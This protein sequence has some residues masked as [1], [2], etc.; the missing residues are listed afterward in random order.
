MTYKKFSANYTQRQNKLRIY[1]LNH[2]FKIQLHALNDTA[3]A[4]Q[5]RLLVNEAVDDSTILI[6][7]NIKKGINVSDSNWVLIYNVFRGDTNDIG[8]SKDKIYVL[9][10]NL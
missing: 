7:Q 10:Y 1:H 9:L 2:F 8:A 6:F 5:F 3:Q 4:I